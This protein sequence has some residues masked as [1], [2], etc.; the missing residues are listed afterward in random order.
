[1]TLGSVT[2]KVK[3][4]GAEANGKTKVGPY[5]RSFIQSELSRGAHKSPNR[6]RNTKSGNITPV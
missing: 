6:V 2:P 1:M 3:V 5:W 4:G